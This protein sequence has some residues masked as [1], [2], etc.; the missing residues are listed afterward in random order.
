MQVVERE[1]DEIQAYRDVNQKEVHFKDC[2]FVYIE[3]KGMKCI[4]VHFFL[5]SAKIYVAELKMTSR[6]RAFMFIP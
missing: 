4:M 5:Q 2:A 3:G 6:G 1:A